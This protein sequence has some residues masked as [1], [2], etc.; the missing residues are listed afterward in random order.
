MECVD[1]QGVYLKSLSKRYTFLAILL[2]LLLLSMLYFITLGPANISIAEVYGVL[3]KKIGLSNKE[4]SG[5]IE[6]V[7]L[8][9][10]MPRVLLAVITGLALGSSGVVM[11]SLLNNPLASPY[12]LGVSSG[13]AFGAGL[14]IVLG[15]VIFGGKFAKYGSWTIIFGAF[16]MGL[17]TILLINAIAS[18]KGGSASVLIL[19]GVALSYLFSAGVSLLKYLTDHEQLREL[20]VWLMGGLYRAE[21][22]DIIILTPIVLLGVLVLYKFAWDINTLNA[23]EE[24]AK[25][26]GINVEKLRRNGCVITAFLTSS[27]IAFTGIIGFIGLIAPHICRMVIGNDNR[28]LIISSGLLGAIILLAAD[29]VARIIINPAELPVGIITSICGVPFFLYLVIKKRRSYW[30]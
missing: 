15:G 14:S 21:W 11:Q 16:L 22:I 8:Q 5:F 18:M 2:I 26:L 24:V 30:K 28:F 27:V 13:S 9:L 23:G 10:R 12:T 3:L 19:S 20:T 17:L 6:G 1:R 4:Y 29:T 25:N 7:I